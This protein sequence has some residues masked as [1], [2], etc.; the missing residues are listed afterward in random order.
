M[1]AYWQL[2]FLIAGGIIF[3]LYTSTDYFKHLF[4]LKYPISNFDYGQVLLFFGTYVL[5]RV[6]LIGFGL[7][8]ILRTVWL[9]Y[10]AISYWYPHDVNY[11]N[12]NVNFYQKKN[13]QE[14]ASAKTR[15]LNLDKWANLSFGITIIF[16]FIVFSS[17]I[18]LLSIQFILA[19]LFGA[20]W[21]I[22]NAVFNYTSAIFVLLLQLGI[23]DFILRKK[24]R[25]GAFFKIGEWLYTIYYY[26][27]GLFFYRRELLVLRT[28]GKTWILLS[29]GT[30]YLLTALFI[31]INQIGEFYQAGTFNINL[32]DDRETYDSSKNYVVDYKV[33]EDQLSKDEVFFNGGIQSAYITDNHLKVF[34]VHHRKYDWY[35]KYVQDSLQY[36]TY[37]PPQSD[38]LKRLYVQE[39]AR[40]NRLV[41]NRL[42]QVE[43]DD[44]LYEDLTWDRYKHYKTKEEGYITYIPIDTLHKGRHIID[45]YTR[46]RFT[47]QVKSSYCFT[48]PFYVD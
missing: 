33:Y 3:S 28:N 13:H 10:F 15:L 38:S 48:V 37:D 45:A 18:V 47:N 41:L 31:S 36:D 5:T 21:L 25:R 30:A 32:F 44:I 22:N 39:R 42:L 40:L 43:I 7:N 34:V 27:S 17:I 16:T 8:L 29:F 4:L 12:I 19:E 46:N 23:F 24:H 11:E 35:L 26:G 2:E 6:L 20:Y 9:A 14:Q 1:P